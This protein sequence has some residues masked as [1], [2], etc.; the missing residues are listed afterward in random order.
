[1]PEYKYVGLDAPRQFV[2]RITLNRPEKKNALSHAL[3]GELFQA[4]E[5][6]DQDAAVR[7]IIL[8]GAGSCFSAGYDLAQSPEEER[9]WYTA[10]GFG[11]WPRHVVDGWFRIWDLATPVIAQIHGYCLAGATE[12]ATACDLVYVAD[13]AKIGYPPVRN[14]SPPD[15]Q[16]YP[17]ILGFRRAMELMLTGDHISGTE[18]AESG[19]A[20]AACPDSELEAHVLEMAE[21]VAKT[22]ADI[23]QINKRAVHRQMEA[24][25][26]RAAIRA[27]SEMT[28]LGLLTA[29]S[30]EYLATIRN[31]GLGAALASRDAKFGAYSS[32]AARRASGDAID[33][34]ED[35]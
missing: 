14:I 26:I 32:N 27:G 18:A 17:W 13:T 23:Q 8:R 35:T 28:Q 22:P 34:A 2:Q 6:A 5:Q 31:A 16:F 4:L 25:G 21:R 33:P 9:P 12:L 10:G 24:R 1:M 30:Q 20:N 11:E 3:R 19:F 29:T 7:V 15:F